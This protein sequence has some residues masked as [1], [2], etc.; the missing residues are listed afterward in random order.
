MN[1]NPLISVIVPVYNVEKY[2]DRCIQSIVD[3]TYKDIEIILVDDGSPDNCPKMCDEWAQKDSRIKVIHK[4]N[5]GVSS[6]RN[7]GI[8]AANGDFIGFVDGD[9]F[10]NPQFYET[11]V[12]QAEKNKADIS[13]CYFNYF[14]DDYSVYKRD[15]CYIKSQKNF[16]SKELLNDYFD[17]CKGEWVSFCNKIIRSCLFSGLRF[18]KNRVFEDWTL[19]P[20]I[21]SR[22]S[23][24]CFIPKPLYGYVIHS[25]SAVRTR[26]IK[27]FYDCV[28][29]DYDHF[30]YFNNL[31]IT[32]FNENIRGFAKSDF[33]KCIKVYDNSDT[34]AKMLADAYKK[35]VEMGS[36]SKAEK[37]MFRF[38]LVFKMLYK[39]KG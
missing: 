22:A 2:L 36:I 30:R 17:S 11:L 21:Y 10:I 6:A 16:T 19:A 29:A 39:L 13:A 34:C 7:A 31:G 5:E 38:P 23:V 27:S 4:K 8:D 18:P 20:M 33:R 28:L 14:N 12:L 26:N 3:Q 37:I 1:N 24:I 32:D 25:G 15:E 9:D 35:C